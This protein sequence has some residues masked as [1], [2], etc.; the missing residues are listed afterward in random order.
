MVASKV[1]GVDAVIRAMNDMG[2]KFARLDTDKLVR[3]AGW[4]AG[5]TAKKMCPPG[6]KSRAIISRN[7]APVKKDIHERTDTVRYATHFVVFRRQGKK[8][9]FVPITLNP[10]ARITDEGI[11]P[12]KGSED[13]A[14]FDSNRKRRSKF[15][16][17]TVFDYQQIRKSTKADG[18]GRRYVYDKPSEI[19]SMRKI[20]RRGLAGEAWAHL[21]NKTGGG[22]LM[23]L[24]VK[25]E[26]VLTKKNK[27]VTNSDVR[28]W[29][30]YK[31]KRSDG[32]STVM[33]HNKLTYL[34]DKY[35]NIEQA[36]Y[37]KTAYNLNV[38]TEKLLKKRADRA[39]ARMDRAA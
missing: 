1:E 10:N 34:R 22:R 24:K 9:H 17:M 14:K 28:K 23:S 33:L 21:G 30:D 4:M 11:A 37:A 3:R 38:M 27:N 29:S 7:S 35:G 16:P 26:T 36:I 19:A 13:Y 18:K 6:D 2:D 12:K 20:G 8:P 32:E 15:K 5:A 25:G 31:H 39:Q